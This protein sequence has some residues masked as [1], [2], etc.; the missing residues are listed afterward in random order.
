VIPDDE[1]F[2]AVETNPQYAD[3]SP[4]EKYRL[5]Q[6]TKLIRLCVMDK[7]SRPQK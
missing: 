4:A 2:V 7:A 3:K 5:A 6:A 1:D